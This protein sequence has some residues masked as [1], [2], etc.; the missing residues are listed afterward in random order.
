M[1]KE[2][3]YFTLYEL[4][5]LRNHSLAEAQARCIDNIPHRFV[6]IEME[7]DGNGLE[8]KSAQFVTQ[9]D[10]DAEEANARALL[11]TML[12]DMNGEIEG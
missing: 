5:S 4:E 1:K 9:D 11:E 12:A 3:V 8:I 10:M 2:S 6:R 7:N